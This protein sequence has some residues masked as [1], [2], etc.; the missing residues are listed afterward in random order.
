MKTFDVYGVQYSADFQK[1]VEA[2]NHANRTHP[3]LYHVDVTREMPQAYLV[4]VRELYNRPHS[5]S[6]TAPGPLSSTAAERGRHGST[7]MAFVP[8]A[9]IVCKDDG[10][11]HEVESFL[12]EMQSQTSFRLFDHEDAHPESYKQLALQG[13]HRYLHE[14]GNHYCWMTVQVGDTDTT[15]RITFE[16][17][18]RVLPRTCHNFVQLCVGVHANVTDDEAGA[19][20]G[21]AAVE[22]KPASEQQQQEQEQEQQQRWLC[23]RDTTFFRV[24]KDAW[25]MGGD[26]SNGH[27]GEGG[28][29]CYGRYFPDESFA[30]AHDG[31][32]VLGMCNDG[33]HTNASSFYITRKKMSWMNG[34]Y[35]AFGR[36]IDGMSAVD[37]I[38]D[39]EVKH[40]QSPKQT[41]RIVD[42]G[43]LD[44]TM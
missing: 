26:V 16:L 20:A 25:V 33:P 7:D 18:S 15:Q 44:V 41:I 23:Y 22:R 13:W 14:R 3:D 9:I 30:I 17:Y 37:A 40:N 29:S 39:V 24:L 36:V 38:F 28:Y 43:V 31:P 19:L 10:E 21:S 27:R 34:H 2:A 32:G 8:E 42:C 12:R 1:C 4:R 11:L 5:P 6:S 35:V